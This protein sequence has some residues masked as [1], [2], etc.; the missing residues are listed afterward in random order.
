MIINLNNTRQEYKEYIG[1]FLTI[2]KKDGRIAK[3]ILKDITSDGKLKV[4]GDYTS[5]VISPESI[6]DL[7]ARPDKTGEMDVKG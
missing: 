5:W 4:E 3:G 7:T 1:Q 2:V 6:Q